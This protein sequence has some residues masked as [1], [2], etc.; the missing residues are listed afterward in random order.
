MI[1]TLTWVSGL[2]HLSGQS[3]RLGRLHGDVVEYLEAELTICLHVSACVLV[4]RLKR[5]RNR[6]VM[7]VTGL[8]P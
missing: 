1:N 4:N 8:D 7:V 2:L 3:S 5:F 6:V